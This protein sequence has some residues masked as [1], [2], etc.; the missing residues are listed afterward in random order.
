MA[1]KRGV[2]K[3]FSEFLVCM[4]KRESKNPFSE[5]L[6]GYTEDISRD[7]MHFRQNV[8]ARSLR[9]GTEIRGLNDDRTTHA[10]QFANHMT[11]NK[12]LT[13]PPAQVYIKV[14]LWAGFRACVIAII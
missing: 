5:F 7:Q 11:P 12:M 1:H 2:S 4:R 8:I 10:I 14:S 3:V 6:A 13:E 9:P